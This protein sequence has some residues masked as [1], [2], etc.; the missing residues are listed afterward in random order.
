MGRFIYDTARNTN[1]LTEAQHLD[2]RE[3]SSVSETG[4]ATTNIIGQANADVIYGSVFRLSMVPVVMTL[5]ELE[6]V[7]ILFL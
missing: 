3:M 1:K 5:L 7:M 4:G 2:L 6:L